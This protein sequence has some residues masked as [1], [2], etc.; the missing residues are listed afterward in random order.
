MKWQIAWLAIA[1]GLFFYWLSDSYTPRLTTRAP[2]GKPLQVGSPLPPGTLRPFQLADTQFQVLRRTFCPQDL[3][4]S[5]LFLS[6]ELHGVGLNQPVQGYLLRFFHQYAGVRVL[7]LEQPFSVVKLAQH[8]LETGLGPDLDAYLLA[9]H[10]SYAYTQQQADFLRQLRHYNQAQPEAERI[11]LVGLDLENQFAA[12][13]NFLH[14]LLPSSLPLA[15]AP[16]REVVDSLDLAV[17]SLAQVKRLAQCLDSSLRHQAAMWATTLPAGPLTELRQVSILLS[18]QL[19]VMEHPG[20]GRTFYRLR[21]AAIVQAFRLLAEQVPPETKFF[22]QWGQAH[23]FPHSEYDFVPWSLQ[24]QSGQDSA[25][26]GRVLGV[27]ISYQ[28]CQYRNQRG[29][30]QPI[31]IETDWSPWLAPAKSRPTDS[32]SSP[33][34][35]FA[36][37]RAGA[38]VAYLVRVNH[39]PAAQTWPGPSVD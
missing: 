39:S 15:L 20:F 17:P 2:A 36:R 37:L 14:Q 25:W 33:T 26:A 1:S 4:Q 10:Y 3:A 13:A 19:Q 22:G 35:A 27:G 30:A 38:P 16:V 7:V 11:R 32:L 9:L 28:A 5:R 29:Q 23:V 34:L 6:G 31:D 12:T 24:L 18:A 8:Y 21:E